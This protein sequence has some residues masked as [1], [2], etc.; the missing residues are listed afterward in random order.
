[1]KTVIAGL[2]IL[3]TV[4]PLPAFAQGERAKPDRITRV[5]REGDKTAVP[6]QL[7]L[8]VNYDKSKQYPL[9]LCL[10]GAGEMKSKEFE[11]RTAA[12][13]A[14]L[15]SEARAKYPAF[16]LVPQ[17]TSGWVKRPGRDIVKNG[18][19]LADIPESASLKLVLKALADTMKEYRV[20]PDRVYVTG[21]SMG[22]VATW[23]VIIRH[24][25]LFAAAVPV[26]G[27]GDTTQAG[28]IRCPVWVFHGAED[29]TVPVTF[30]REMV[31]ALKA[32]GGN[33]K[34]TEYPEV[35][36]GSWVPAWQEKELIPWLF[37]QRRKKE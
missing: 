3:L 12:S 6:Y 34:Y 19:R 35:G 15:K 36:H 27:V 31:K 24:P 29:K 25:D 18:Y 8:P 11:A 10:H 26:C 17:T 20:D 2:A 21:Q 23:D 9:V 37:S 30:S 4:A 7:Y 28:K 22:G 33:V 5:V 14:L 16:I 1:M 32:A 13:T